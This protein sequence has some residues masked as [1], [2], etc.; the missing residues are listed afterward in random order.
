LATN[1]EIQYAQRWSA[2]EL[3]LSTH[4]TMTSDHT[5]LGWTDIRHS[6]INPSHI[7]MLAGS[8]MGGGDSMLPIVYIRSVPLANVHLL[9]FKICH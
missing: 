5:Y 8:C 2:Y 1:P 4:N 6:L 3:L 7:P 9:A